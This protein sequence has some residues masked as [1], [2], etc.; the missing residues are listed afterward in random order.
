MLCDMHS[1]GAHELLQGYNLCVNWLTSNANK[2]DTSWMFPL[3]QM[4]QEPTHIFVRLLCLLS[5]IND[6]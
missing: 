1:V 6:K 3:I 2:F 4:Q 5:L